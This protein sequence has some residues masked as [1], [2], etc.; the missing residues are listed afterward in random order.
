MW[1]QLIIDNLKYDLNYIVQS[2]QLQNTLV[3]VY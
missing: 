2:D 1:G 3:C